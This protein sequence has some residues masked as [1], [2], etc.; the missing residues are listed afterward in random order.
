MWPEPNTLPLPQHCRSSFCYFILC[1][2][3]LSAHTLNQN[4]PLLFKSSALENLPQSKFTPT[5]KFTLTPNRPKESLN[6]A[7]W[8]LAG[9]CKWIRTAFKIP[10]GEQTVGGTNQ[11]GTKRKGDNETEHRERV[12]AGE[13]KWGKV[14]AKRERGWR[15]LVFLFANS[16]FLGND[17]AVMVLSLNSPNETRRPASSVMFISLHFSSFPFFICDIKIIYTGSAFHLYDSPL[18]SSPFSHLLPLFFLAHSAEFSGQSKDLW[19]ASQRRGYFLRNLC[20]QLCSLRPHMLTW[21]HASWITA[22]RH[23][24][25]CCPCLAVTYIDLNMGS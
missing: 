11:R 21:A 3:S 8:G 18:F 25:S 12:V 20:Q 24:G 22:E 9:A 17:R 10:S 15:S 23:S 1:I 19:L 2:G 14:K 5:V 7:R 16:G 6:A 13:R 4:F